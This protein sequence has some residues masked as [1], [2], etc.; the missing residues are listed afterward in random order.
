MQSLAP[1][2]VPADEAK[3][4]LA[5]ILR[6]RLTGLSWRQV[7]E[8]VAGRRVKVLGEVCLDSARRLK[9]G[10][11]VELLA[12][13][14]RIESAKENITIRHIDDHVVIV[15]K[16][17]GLSTVRHPAERDWADRR[18]TLSPTL[19][20]IVPALITARE[21]R[22]CPRLRIVQRL[23]KE[24]S[25]LVVFARSVT[26]ERGLGGQFRAHT[27]IRRYVAIVP[28]RIKDQ[29]I[30]SFLVRDR[31]DG[32]RGSTTLKDVG[33]E[34]ITHIEATERLKGYTVV[35]CRLETGKTHQIRIHLAEL[36]HPVCGDR[37]YIHRSDGTLFADESGAPR[38]ALHAT[39]LGFEHPVSGQ[40][41]RWEMP[42]PA[43]LQ[44]FLERLRGRGRDDDRD[45]MDR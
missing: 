21:G 11:A 23:D 34:A 3:A 42:L 41:M 27:V 9:E 5:A 13:P 18:K 39:E 19:E 25:G 15:E 40:P 4:T 16:P 29:R 6:A 20:D 38:L 37:V 10:D 32:R 35:G 12:R 7:R 33:K 2:L 17:S 1:F 43:D 44:A 24:T 22:R 8:L 26:A 36:G 30:H 28:G 14:A 31:G 45:Q